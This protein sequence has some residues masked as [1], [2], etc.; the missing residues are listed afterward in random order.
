[1]RKRYPLP[2][3]ASLTGKAIIEAHNDPRY[4]RVKKNV[5]A[6]IF[7]GTPHRGAEKAAYLKLIL[8]PFFG[9]IFV[10]ELQPGMEMIKTISSQFRHRAPS[11][12]IV[13]C[14]E[15]KGVSI[16]GVSLC[17]DFPNV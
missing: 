4:V 5:K 13:S 17:S 10:D 6:V 8:T 12:E 9:K 15:Q 7:L 16:I 1:L 14:F 11:L 3:K 2:A